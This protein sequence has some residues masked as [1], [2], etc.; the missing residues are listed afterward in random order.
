M[1]INGI[2]YIPA[3][4][5]LK[6]T[7]DLSRWQE[8]VLPEHWKAA[9]KEAAQNINYVREVAGDEGVDMYL[10]ELLTELIHEPVHIT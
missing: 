9:V 1:M 8:V 10:N 7:P 6:P 5:K 4:G 3:P 2:S